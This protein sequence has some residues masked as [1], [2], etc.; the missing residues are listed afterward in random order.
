MADSTTRR[1]MNQTEIIPIAY[2]L[3][4]VIFSLFS[5]S[6]STDDRI[7]DSDSPEVI[8]IGGGLM[9]SSAAWK[10]AQSGRS[11]LLL[12][13]QDEQ[14]DSGSSLG[15]AR[16]ARS[17]NRGNDIWS[18]M[19]NETVEEVKGLID[20]LNHSES[21]Q[22]FEISDI[23]TTSAVSYLGTKAIYDQLMSSLTRQK[24]NYKIATDPE[25]AA[26]KFDVNIPEGVLIQ[27]EYNQYS[28]TINPE[29]LIEYLHKA[30]IMAGGEVLYDTEVT[31][32][33]ENDHQ[34]K[35][36][37]RHGEQNNS[38]S[39]E[40]EKLVVAAGPY[41]GSLLK[42]ILPKIERLVTPKRVFLAFYRINKGIYSNFSDKQKMLLEAGYPVINSS[43]GTRKGSFFSMIEYYDEDDLP[44]IKIG[45]HFQRSPI[46]NLENVWQTQLTESE[47]KW[48]FDNTLSY[49]NLL[50]LNIREDD[51]EFSHGYSCVYSLTETE[52]PIVSPAQSQSGKYNSDFV[53]IAGMS[54]VGAKGSL[55]YGKIA[56]DIITNQTETDSMYQVVRNAF[57]MDRYTS[58]D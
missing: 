5:N 43:A 29:K 22:S 33:S 49:L 2:I 21:E 48:A 28:G 4:F 10:L 42:E 8:I 30:V 15:E 35:I 18:Y 37:A 40:T 25:D 58:E 31:S 50:N 56:S 52:V 38:R 12:E 23:Y 51:L 32:I 57:H 17:N 7:S 14:Y 16:I 11:V 20:F 34:F 24:V 13:K 54:G 39:F 41:A 6:C 55:M 1:K 26:E 44:I 3:M 19:H 27:R 9:G 53:I 45:G 46:T 36:V 47:K